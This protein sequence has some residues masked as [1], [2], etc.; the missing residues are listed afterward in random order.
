MSAMDVPPMGPRCGVTAAGKFL[1]VA[2]I[3]PLHREIDWA[4]L[5][6]LG[7]RAAG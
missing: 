7:A 3:A 5:L 4:T 2:T 6:T 1:L